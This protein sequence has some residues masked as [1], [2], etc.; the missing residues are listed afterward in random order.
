[1]RTST[2][3]S[4]T[5]S[6]HQ[7]IK[8]IQ[9]ELGDE[10]GSPE[11]KELVEKART[12][13]WSEETKKVFEKELS[14][15]D[16]LNPQSPDYNVQMTYLQTLVSLPW[17]EYTEDDLDLHRARRVLDRDHYGME[18]VKERIL[19]Y[20]A[21]LQLKGNL[22]SPILC[23]YGPPEWERLHSGKASPRH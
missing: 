18:K 3:S 21:V 23:L 19:E 14:K 20:I 15:L 1:M 4:A 9:E 8:N 16:N 22:K 13:K 17:N 6:L 5:I 10:N 2:H 12:R 7:Q 11:R